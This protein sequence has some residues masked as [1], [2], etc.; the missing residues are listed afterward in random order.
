MPQKLQDFSFFCLKAIFFFVI[1][2]LLFLKNP[3]WNSIKQEWIFYYKRFSLKI[4][5]KYCCKGLKYCKFTQKRNK[6]KHVMKKD[7]SKT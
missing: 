4:T 3:W 1:S 2:S 5:S 7:Y 6:E